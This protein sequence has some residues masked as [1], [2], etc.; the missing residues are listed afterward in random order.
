MRILTLTMNP[1]IDKSTAVRHLRPE[2]KLSCSEPKREP[3]GG[4]INVSRA[5]SK[6]SGDSRALFVSGGLTGRLLE[7]LLTQESIPCNVWP[8]EGWVRENLI[9]N[10]TLNGDQYRFGMPGPKLQIKEWQGIL[11]H[12]ENLKPFPD[13]LV[14]SGSL[15][16]GVPTDFYAQVTE[17]VRRRGGKI[18]LDTKGQALKEALEG[19]QVFML[20][21]NLK[22]LSA[23]AGC[24]E[25]QGV[26]H[27]RISKNLVDSGKVEVVVV[28]LGAR[29]GMMVSSQGIEYVVPPPVTVKSLVGAGDSMVAGLTLAYAKG[30]EKARF[31]GLWGRLRNGSSHE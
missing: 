6:L 30:I 7:E 10:Q 31:T 15:P 21:P 14:A 13:L 18:I 2:V 25:I 4:G 5:I 9:V 16:V 24:D 23:L 27:E 20:K 29:G 17:I 12:L 19:E 22:E 11:K 8:I 26:E 3:G 28:S 1:A